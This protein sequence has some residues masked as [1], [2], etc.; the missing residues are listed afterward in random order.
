[1]LYPNKDYGSNKIEYRVVEGVTVP[2]ITS[3]NTEATNISKLQSLMIDG[4]FSKG[5]SGYIPNE[6]HLIFFNGRRFV[7]WVNSKGFIHMVLTESINGDHYRIHK[8]KNTL[9]Y[10]KDSGYDSR[11][12]ISSSINVIEKRNIYK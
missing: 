11:R 1:M 2:L 5:S 7:V 3:E 12:L 8:T 6:N 10:V 9:D 4:V